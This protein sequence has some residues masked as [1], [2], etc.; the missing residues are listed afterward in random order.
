[1]TTWFIDAYMYMHHPATMTQFKPHNKFQTTINGQG[2]DFLEING[3]VQDFNNSSALAMELLKSST[4]PEK[5]SQVNV[6]N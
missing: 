6:H 2:T 3:S 1:M 5:Y 4:K